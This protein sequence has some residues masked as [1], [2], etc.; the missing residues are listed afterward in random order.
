MIRGHRSKSSREPNGP[1]EAAKYSRPSEKKS[2]TFAIVGLGASAG[3]LMALLQADN[4][5]KVGP[6]NI[7]VIP[8]NKQMAMTHGALLLPRLP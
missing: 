1:K 3:G 7:Y 5:T 6:S 8:R 4:G 2:Q